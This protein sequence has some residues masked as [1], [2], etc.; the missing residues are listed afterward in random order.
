[1]EE[2][3]IKME[4]EQAKARVKIMEGEEQKLEEIANQED[5]DNKLSEKLHF[6]REDVNYFCQNSSRFLGAST[7]ESNQRHSKSAAENE[8]GDEDQQGVANKIYKLF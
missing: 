2:L 3:K 6:P 5:L 8:S 1:M 4:I 7:T